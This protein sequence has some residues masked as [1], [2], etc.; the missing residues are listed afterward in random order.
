LCYIQA[1]PLSQAQDQAGVGKLSNNQ[2]S[3][4]DATPGVQAADIALLGQAKHPDPFSVLGRHLLDDRPYIRCFIPR[5]RSV[6][7][8][9]ES[10]PMQRIGDSD[11]FEYSGNLESLPWHYRLIW[12][13]DDGKR[14]EA[15]DPY[16]FPPLLQ[17]GEMSEFAAGRHRRA[18]EMLGARRTRVEG[19][20]GTLFS[21]WAPNAGRVSVVGGFNHW[22]GRCHPM[23]LH[24]G[25]GIWELFIP[26]LDAGSYK[27]E[28]L[29]RHDGGLFTRADPYA[30]WS[31]KRPANASLVPP[32]AAHRWRDDEWM[33]RRAQANWLQQP[34]SIYELHLGSWRRGPEDR[35]LSYREIAVQLCDHVR[36]LGFTH[37]ELL[38]MK[39]HPLDESWG[40]QTTGYFA[41]TSRHGS[42]DDFRAFVDHMHR[43]GI[44]VLLDWVPA[45]FPRDEHGLANF[46]G[47]ALY[48][49]HDPL[50]AEHRDWGTL[51][52][53]YERKE[54]RSFLISNALYWLRDFHL[55]GL[56]VDAVASMLYLNFSR[57]E[58]QWTPNR[59][60]GN[61][62]LEAIEFLKELNAT[63]GHECA[64]CLMIAEE[65]S[66][67]DGVTRDTRQGGLGFD[68]KWNMGWM[69]DTLDY[70][71]KEP[72]HRK[73]HQQWLTFGPL[74]VYDEHFVLPL[75]HDE[76]VH[77]KKSLYG[78]M[79]G[80]EWQRFANLRLLYCYQWTYPGKQ[81]LFMGGEFAQATEW[82][83]GSALPWQRGEE[84]F[85]AGVMALLKDLNRLQAE[86]P[87]LSEWDCDAR[88][89]EWLE[90]D[91]RE[92]SVISFMRHAAGETA[93]VVLNFTPVTR[94]DYR[95]GVP[96]PG[97]YQE[98]F[99][100][101]DPAYLGSG[102]LNP[103]PIDSQA[104]PWHGRE[105]SL[106]LTLP[107]LAG[108]VLFARET[109]QS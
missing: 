107:P 11:L 18:Q 67:W 40:Y 50:K 100:S 33:S 68:F 96:A 24:P 51:V 55:D 64:G 32:E 57:Q 88:G 52:F 92:Q 26:G 72:V 8:E 85:A 53:N 13:A 48:E 73:F 21:V 47:G 74:Y 89:F 90:G 22:D 102:Q 60:G 49:Y 87:A 63:V 108:V 17:S 78:R 94:Q 25:F 59:Y 14:R 41:P 38:P 82:D 46:D 5:A 58:E 7:V 36:S 28:I 34:V 84:P 81:L 19:I 79:P 69:H 29:N 37:I 27:Y 4:T 15:C 35:F 30:R 61:E 83:S 95:I 80:D 71:S 65:S 56:R 45:H 43:N 97:Q 105:N 20:G 106:C 109:V 99:N 42:P 1:E 9:D 101:D 39:E 10:R 77:L 86:H 44:G 76:V 12:D 54:V 98:Q 23:R 104:L 3:R 66:A 16:S 6:W 2:Q 70:F 75:S 91:D 103:H 93:I 62:N 31:E